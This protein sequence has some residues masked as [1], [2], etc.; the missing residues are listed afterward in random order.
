VGLA[1]GFIEPL[2][3]TSIHMIMSSVVRLLRFFPFAGMNPAQ[4]AQYNDQTRAEIEH[5]RDFVCMHYY[6][7]K[8]DDT[9]FWRHC[10]RMEIPETLQRRIELFRENAYVWQGAGEVFAIDSWVAVM[11]GQGIEPR[12]Y[13]H[14]ARGGDAELMNHMAQYR[15]RV[16]SVVDQ[17]PAH[18]DFVRQYCGA[19][20]TAWG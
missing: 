7:T 11:M 19:E 10:S 20:E 5:I 9:P 6:L 14:Y 15:A 2:E 4:T 13:H 16:S 8:R 17:L 12:N 18:H 3:S 1:G